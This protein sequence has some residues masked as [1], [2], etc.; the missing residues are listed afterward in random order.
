MAEVVRADRANWKRL[1]TPARREAQTQSPHFQ[2]FD[3]LVIFVRNRAGN[4]PGRL[5]PEIDSFQ[6]LARA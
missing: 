3:R 4:H 1:L 6:V 2:L 5:Q